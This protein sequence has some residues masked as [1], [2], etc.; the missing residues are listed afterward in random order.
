MPNGGG[1]FQVVDPNTEEIYYTRAGSFEATNEGVLVT[2]DQYR[3]QLQGVNGQPNLS[4]NENESL[5]NRRIEENGEVNLIV[6]RTNPNGEVEDVLRNAG[7][8]R[9]VNFQSP[10]YLRRA[11]NCFYSNGALG[12]DLAGIVD[13]FTPASGSN[14]KIKQYSLELSNVDLTSQFAS[15]ISHQRSFQAGSRVV[16]TSDEILSEAVNFKR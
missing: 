13:N 6:S 10:Q 4:L 7:Q 5:I 9:L 12:Q 14:G 2:R 16:T 11:G 8:I 3:Y 1:F 15:M